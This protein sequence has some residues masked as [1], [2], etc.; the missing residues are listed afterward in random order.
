MAV[1]NRGGSSLIYKP[2]LPIDGSNTVAI[3]LYI[4][5]PG[6]GRPR[7]G[8]E[9]LKCRPSNESWLWQEFIK[10]EDADLPDWERRA[11]SVPGSAGLPSVP[12][13]TTSD[14]ALGVLHDC[15]RLS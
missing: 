11:E 2:Q 13:E 3:G 14:S 10:W 15:P 8:T 5:R 9:R 12:L 7:L 1:P 4:P 6:I